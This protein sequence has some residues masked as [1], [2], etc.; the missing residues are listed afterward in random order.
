[1]MAVDNGRLPETFF[2]GN[3]FEV[4]SILEEGWLVVSEKEQGLNYWGEGDRHELRVV[5]V[6][7]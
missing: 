7:R 6:V 2:L 5:V 3:S 1:M 4:L